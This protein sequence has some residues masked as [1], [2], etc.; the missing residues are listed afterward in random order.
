MQWRVIG[1]G[2]YKNSHNIAA[3][4]E[5]WKIL[6]ELKNIKWYSELPDHTKRTINYALEIWNPSLNFAVNYDCNKDF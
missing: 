6:K 5:W 4:V 3:H 2:N 1:I